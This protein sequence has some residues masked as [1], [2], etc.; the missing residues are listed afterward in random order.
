M[1]DLASYYDIG[2]R[3]GIEKTDRPRRPDQILVGTERAETI[4]AAARKHEK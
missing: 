4:V 1:A 2:N 3:K